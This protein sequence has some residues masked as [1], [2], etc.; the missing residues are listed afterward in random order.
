MKIYLILTLLFS[1]LPKAQNSNAEFLRIPVDKFKGYENCCI[2]RCNMLIGLIDPIENELRIYG[3]EN[4]SNV[5]AY[6]AGIVAKIINH[7]N[8]NSKSILVKSNELV[9][10]Y[11]NLTNLQII[12]NEKI[13]ENQ[14]L[15]KIMTINS[16]NYLG[17]EIWNVNSE[18]LN[19]INYLKDNP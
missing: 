2:N 16:E 4:Q 3:Y 14:I 18:K 1:I 8:D 9:F 12:E 6:K 7:D 10:V 11:K 5:L 15:G 13:S 17:F 19:P